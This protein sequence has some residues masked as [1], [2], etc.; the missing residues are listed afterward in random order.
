M[1]NMKGI[2]QNYLDTQPQGLAVYTLTKA[3]HEQ[4]NGFSLRVVPD[5]VWFATNT[6]QEFLG[7][8]RDYLLNC[9]AYIDSRAHA[10]TTYRDVKGQ[11]EW[12]LL[13]PTQVRIVTYVENHQDIYKYEETMPCMKCG[14]VL[15]ADCLTV[16]HQRPQKG[17]DLEAIL[18]NFRV[19]G[20]TNE[21]PQGAK[22][23]A[24]MAKFQNAAFLN[25][26]PTKPGRPAL[27]GTSVTAR[28]TLNDPGT[29]LY[30]LFVG[31]G[32]EDELKRRCMNSLFNL[33]PLCL[34]CN[35]QKGNKLKEFLT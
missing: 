23:K 29:M 3:V 26:L 7:Y 13:Y 11:V 33:A 16:D 32:K 27:A 9:V 31:A 35:A 22:G 4:V 17:G 8:K 34:R 15:P 10:S 18:K 5:G 14:I 28:Y 25:R 6:Q 30:S 21:G 19:L 24:L 12:Q 20:L 1:S 2:L